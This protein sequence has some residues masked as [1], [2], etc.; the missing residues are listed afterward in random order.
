MAIKMRV[1]KETNCS[2]SECGAS[3][4]NVLDMYDIC[5]A[6]KVFTICDL[7]N[8]TLFQKSLKAQIHTQSR[9]KSN[10]DIKIIDARS[11]KLRKK[12]TGLSVA[13]ALKGEK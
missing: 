5:I 6:G 1:N 12:D 11:L 4:K 10:R 2:C 3:R 9:L 7:C 13:E 8:D